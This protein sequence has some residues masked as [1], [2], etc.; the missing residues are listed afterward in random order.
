[1]KITRDGIDAIGPL[2]TVLRDD[3]VNTPILFAPNEHRSVPAQGHAPGIGDVGRIETDG[4]SGRQG[5]LLQRQRAGAGT[6]REN[7]QGHECRRTIW[8][9]SFH[10]DPPPIASRQIIVPPGQILLDGNQNGSLPFAV[11]DIE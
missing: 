4:E 5:D 11:E 9:Q 2:M 10:H 8:D 3:G 1:M 7:R 6:V